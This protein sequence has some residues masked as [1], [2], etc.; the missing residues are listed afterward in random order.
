MSLNST[1]AGAVDKALNLYI[2]QDPRALERCAALDG[3]IIAVHITGLEVSIY[4]APGS[5]GIRVLGEYEGE[6]DTH[7]S[8]TPMALA[9]LGLA[10]G[11]DALFKGDVK[12]RGDSGT[13]EQFQA[14]LAEVDW[15]WE[16]QLSRITGD[17]VAHQAGELGRAT[18]RILRDSRST[19]E[20]NI[21]E[22]LHEEARLL[23]S[24]PEIDNLLADI[25]TFRS[26]VDRLSARIERLFAA[27]D[28]ER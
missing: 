23:P 4:F 17:L 8:G 14:L 12:I 25:D 20:Q 18:R 28:A 13:G 3:R 15:D 10:A 2:R 9:R 24:R 19:L 27:T 1:L 21:A 6:A 16:E 11:E 5:D 22:Y 26:D 7:L